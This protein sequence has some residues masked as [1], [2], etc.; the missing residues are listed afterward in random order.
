MEKLTVDQIEWGKSHYQKYLE[1]LQPLEMDVEN[2]WIEEERMLQQFQTRFQER[3]R[4]DRE[5]DFELLTRWKWPGL[6]SNYAQNNSPERVRRVTET[7]FS[8]GDRKSKEEFDEIICDQIGCLSCLDGVRPA[9]ASVILTFWRPNEYTVMD[10]RALLTLSRASNEK[11]RW[12]HAPKAS[13]KYYPEYLRV[14]TELRDDLGSEF[15]LRDI[16]RA[17]WALGE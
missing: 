10:E 12:S 17:L 2:R 8:W 6:W 9:M 13:R 5:K 1:R 4:I 3:G 7:A 14:C 15:T 16:D 11:Y